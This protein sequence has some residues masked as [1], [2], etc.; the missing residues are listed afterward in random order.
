MKSL[1]RPSLL[2]CATMLPLP[3][4]L[5]S[6]VQQTGTL[7]LNLQSSDV[8]SVVTVSEADTKT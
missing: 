8:Y 4:V 5:N 7:C 6:D 2:V 3:P 1:E